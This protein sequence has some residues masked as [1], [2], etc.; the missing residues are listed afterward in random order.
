MDERGENVCAALRSQPN[1]DDPI[2]KQ[3]QLHR[4]AISRNERAILEMERDRD[5]TLRRLDSELAEAT[6]AFEVR[7]ACILKQIEETNRGASAKIATRTVLVRSSRDALVVLEPNTA[8]RE[9]PMEARR[10]PRS[11]PVKV[12]IQIHRDIRS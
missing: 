6:R 4:D 7:R 11:D 5:V 12:P 3:A 9:A 10:V 1:G 2:A 8:T